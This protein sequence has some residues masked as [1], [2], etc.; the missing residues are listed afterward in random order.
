M[1]FKSPSTGRTYSDRDV[2]QSWNTWASKHLAPQ[3]KDVLDIGCGGG[4]Y[5]FGFSVLGAKS[6]I[7]IDSSPQYIDEANNDIECDGIVTFQVGN[8]IHTGLS[9][10]CA[11]LVFERAL[12]HHLSTSEQEQNL[13]EVK[14]LLRPKGRAVIQDRTLEDVQSQSPSHWIRSTLFET[15]PQLLDFER[16]RR[17]TK[18]TYTGL[19]VKVG[20][21]GIQK[22]TYEEVR[23]T[24]TDFN[25]LEKE[26]LSRK[27][28]SILFEL[29][30]AE[31]Q[32][33]CDKLRVKSASHPLVER[34]SWTVWVG[35]ASQ[36]Y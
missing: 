31:L 11:D 22:L 18:S 33:Y 9:S 14:R 17:P 32:I 21:Q 12:I 20:F 19:L 5:S 15:Y 3:G 28:K 25:Q 36:V 26:I 2:D 8:A 4:I 27:G 29:S 30:D 1:E 23:K 10:H 6:V 35:L 13:A 16:K 7:G 24:Y 34:D